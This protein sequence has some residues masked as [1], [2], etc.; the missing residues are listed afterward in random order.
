ME[1]RSGEKWKGIEMAR[2]KNSLE[3]KEVRNNG[4]EERKQ[5]KKKGG[6]GKVL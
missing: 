2:K 6:G 4:K 3:R 5:A 1:L